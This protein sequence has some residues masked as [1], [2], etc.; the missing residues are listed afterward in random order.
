MFCFN[1][2]KK[3]PKKEHFFKVKQRTLN[4]VLYLMSF[5]FLMKKGLNSI[6]SV[7]G[8]K[9]LRT[10]P[11]EEQILGDNLNQSPVKGKHFNLS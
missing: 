2:D 11:L 6:E 8:K 5:F 1:F 4:S 10:R 3:N 9:M 7:R